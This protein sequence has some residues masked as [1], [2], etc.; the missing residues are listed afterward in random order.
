MEQNDEFA[1]LNDYVLIKK[2]PGYP[3]T[4]SSWEEDVVRGKC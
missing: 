4:R 2:Y 3:I 1:P